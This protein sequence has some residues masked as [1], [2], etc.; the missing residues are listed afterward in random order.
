MIALIEA[1][2][3]RCLRHVRQPLGPFQVLVGPNASGKSTF[4]DVA[5]FLG[6]LVSESLEYALN[7]RTQ[8]LE[9]LLWMRSGDKFQLAIEFALP[10]SLTQQQ[11]ENGAYKAARYEV[12]IGHLPDSQESGILTERLILL[13]Q[14]KSHRACQQEEFPQIKEFPDSILMAANSKRS[15][16]IITKSLGHNDNFYSEISESSGKGWKPSYKLGPKKSALANLPEDETMFPVATWVKR[17]LGEGVRKF[18]LNSVALRVPSSPE[19]QRGFE[20]DGSNLPWVVHNLRKTAPERFSDWV[21]HLQTALP[22]LRDIHTQEIAYNK[23]R[24]VEIEYAGGLRVPSWTA[25]D[26]TL[27]LLALTLPAYVPGLEGTYLIEEPENGIHPRAVDTMYQS[28]SSVYD[29]QILLA[30]HSPVILNM[31]KP[32]EVLCFAKTEDGATDIISGADHPNLRDWQG[33]TNLGTLFA[34]GVLG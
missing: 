28:L 18:M 29:A 14:H 22:E 30:T 5:A 34:G 13:Q 31:V 19:K 26:G 8:N 10:K 20:T 16:S 23:S 33:K 12:E 9:D 25:S 32:A 27:R 4:L 7:S 21:A 6:D 15:R 24:F 17:V 2:N 3:F 11:P 1:L